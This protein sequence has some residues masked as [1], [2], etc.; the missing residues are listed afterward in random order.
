MSTTLQ[1]RIRT[2]ILAVLLAVF[3]SQIAAQDRV[4][5]VTGFEPFHGASFNPSWEAV[6]LLPEQIGD[7]KLIKLQLRVSYKDGYLP[8]EDAIRR[9]DP[10]GILATGELNAPGFHIEQKAY[11]LDDDI[12]ADNDG[13]VRTNQPI[14][15]LLHIE[16]P[17]N[18]LHA[19]HGRITLPSPDTLEISNS[20]PID[21]IVTNLRQQGFAVEKSTNPMNFL[22]N[23]VFYLL[24]HDLLSQQRHIPAGFI[25]VPTHAYNFNQDALVLETAIKTILEK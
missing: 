4:F 15:T 3:T 24:L 8:L 23:H 7:V 19:T 5:I 13:V 22:C 2:F 12:W 11:N 25:H 6:Q 14:K 20:L 10:I 16:N 17:S 9:Y 1:M 18:G 21:K